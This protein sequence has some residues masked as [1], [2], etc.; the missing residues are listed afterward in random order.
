MHANALPPGCGPTHRTRGATCASSCCASAS[1][2]ARPCWTATTACAWPP[3]WCWAAPTARCCRGWTT[4]TAP[5]WRPGWTHAARSQPCSRPRRCTTRWPRPRPPATWTPRW[6]PPPARPLPTPTA[7]QPCARRCACTTCAASPAPGWR[8]STACA[9]GWPPAT[10]ASPPWPRATWPTRCAAVPCGRRPGT[11]RH[12][13]CR[14]ACS[15]RRC[16]PAAMPSAP[17]CSAPG[18]TAALRW[19]KA[20]PARARAA[21]SPIWPA[22]PTRC[23]RP[24]APATA[25]RPMP[26]WHACWRRCGAARR[27]RWTGRCRTRWRTSPP[28]LH[29][30]RAPHRCGRARCWR[31]SMR[32]WRHTASAP[33]CSTTCTSPMPPRW[34]WPPAW[35]P[36]PGVQGAGCWHSG[37]PNR[38]PQRRRCA[39]A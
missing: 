11:R 4:P 1:N 18:P 37:R 13:A 6:P 21:C 20:R 7:R 5:T 36:A 30:P 34:S 25:A 32:C 23:W 17:P 28:A 8:C 39:T 3:A 15:A 19:S 26:R 33:S 27:P 29:P 14:S 31:R 9:H 38:H 16:W 12:P 2:A 10:A 22:A 35:L 24:A